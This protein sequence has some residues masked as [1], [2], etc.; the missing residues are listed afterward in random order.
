MKW[1]KWNNACITTPSISILF[2]GKP[3][4]PFK[5]DR[6]LRQG[7]PQSPFLFVLL[8]D[9]LNRLLMKAAN[10]GLFRGLSVGAKNVN[11]THL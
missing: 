6:G 11:V 7:D 3:C 2:N 5:M 1:R 9:V 4:K 8:V 10:L